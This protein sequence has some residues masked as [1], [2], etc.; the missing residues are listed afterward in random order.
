VFLGQIYLTISYGFILLGL[1]SLTT[2][3]VWNYDYLCN[4]NAQGEVTI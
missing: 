4:C 3:T 2:C 1:P